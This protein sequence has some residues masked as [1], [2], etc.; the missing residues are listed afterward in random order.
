MKQPAFL[1]VTFLEQ[2]IWELAKK[3]NVLSDGRVRL[4]IFRNEG[5]YYVPTNNDVSYLL[6]VYPL[7]EKGY[8]LNT[9]GYTVD[10][11][12]D[13]AKPINKLS[14]LKSAN[15]LI[16]VMA[17]IFKTE[18]QLDD[19]LLQNDKQRIIEGI[20][21]NVFFVKSGEIYTA[22]LDD[23]CVHGVMRKKIIELAKANKMIVHE[24]TVTESQ[25]LSAD[26]LFLTNAI[27]GIRWVVAFKQK[28]YFNDTSKKLLEKLNE[29]IL[30]E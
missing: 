15:C 28:R 5:G 21:S 12:N 11:F 20:N 18:N 10:L 4:T 19:C 16:Y 3:N 14:A 30:L 27:N 1:S 13:F 9:K 7:A 17:G 2:A 29:L 6:E 25:L 24:I 26:E 8:I 22:S 23:G